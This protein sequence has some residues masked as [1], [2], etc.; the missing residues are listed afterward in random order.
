MDVFA[1]RADAD[2]GR[3]HADPLAAGRSRRHDLGLAQ[4]L[5][6][7]RHQALRPGRLQALRRGRGGDRGAG[8]RPASAWRSPAR[9][10]GRAKR[11]DDARGRYIEFAK[12]TFPK[13]LTPRRPARSSSTAPTAPPT[14]VAPDALW[15]LGAEV[16]AI[17]IEPER[18]QH[19]R[20]LRLDRT[21]RAAGDGARAQRRHRHRARRRRRPADPRRREGQPRSTATS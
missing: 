14:S 17:G 1:G 8:S 13:A 9:Q 2:P 12:S 19:Q 18:P 21:R 3:R 6:R 15:E 16:V 11:I 10:I 20:R 7:Q 4:P 5:P